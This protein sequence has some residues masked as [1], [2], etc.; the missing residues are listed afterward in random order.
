MKTVRRIFSLVSFLVGMTLAGTGRV[1]EADCDEEGDEDGVE[2]SESAGKVAG[3]DE[4]S[5]TPSV[6]TSSEDRVKREVCGARIGAIHAASWAT[7]EAAT[8][9]AISDLNLE[10]RKTETK[11]RLKPKFQPQAKVKRS[12]K[13]KLP[14][15]CL[16]VE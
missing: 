15:L 9:D 6:V 8:R 7:L 13:E 16:L 10:T 4:A 2:G 5:S 12:R 3:S 14:P 11:K 1:V